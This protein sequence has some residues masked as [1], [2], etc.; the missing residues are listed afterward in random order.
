MVVSGHAH[1]IIRIIALQCMMIGDYAG[2]R[3][4]PPKIKEYLATNCIQPIWCTI[5][6]VSFHFISICQTGMPA[7]G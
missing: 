3:K 6:R 1:D 2:I 4:I 5:Y 7:K